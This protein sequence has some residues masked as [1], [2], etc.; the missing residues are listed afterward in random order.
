MSNNNQFFSPKLVTTPA[1]KEQNRLRILVPR[2]IEFWELFI[3]KTDENGEPLKRD[4][5]S[6]SVTP[7]RRLKIDGQIS[8]DVKGA[9]EDERPKLVH[10]YIAWN[11]A[12]NCLQIFSFSQA[13]LKDAISGVIGEARL[14]G[15]TICDFDVT[16]LKTG[17]GSK[18]NTKYSVEC[19]RQKGK[20]VY[21][22]IE[23]SV[24]E[25][26][27]TCKNSGLIK[28]SALIHNEYPF[29]GAAAEEMPQDMKRIAGLLTDGS[30]VTVKMLQDE[31]DYAAAD[32][33][34]K[35]L[36]KKCVNGEITEDGVTY[37]FSDIVN[38]R[39]NKY[40]PF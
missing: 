14:D 40:C 16:V 39:D 21:S 26:Y 13:S 12:L 27:N 2:P 15:K 31:E 6:Y 1:D 32:L 3:T 34:F 30:G 29:S 38:I 8:S 22:P 10:A 28:G 33:I 23:E 37:T 17:D 18:M 4:D 35:S 24:L 7:Y 36:V 19:D 9:K 25:F 5:G 20:I 11:Y